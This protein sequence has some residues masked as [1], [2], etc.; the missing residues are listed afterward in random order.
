M[1]RQAARFFIDPLLI[2]ETPIIIGSFGNFGS[3]N[4][5]STVKYFSFQ[6]IFGLLSSHLTA[7]IWNTKSCKLFKKK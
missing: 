5:L 4:A 3:H 2:A 1:L 7:R 6:K